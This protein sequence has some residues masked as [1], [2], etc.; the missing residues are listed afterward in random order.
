MY[1][2]PVDL[3]SQ[4][5]VLCS[6]IFSLCL[7]NEHTVSLLVCA[8]SGQTQPPCSQLTDIPHTCEPT[9]DC[10]G[11]VCTTLSGTQTATLT[12]KKCSDPLEVDLVLM[13]SG[14]SNSIRY[15]VGGPE[16]MTNNS[17]VGQHRPLEARFSRNTTHLMFTVSCMCAVIPLGCYTVSILHQ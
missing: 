5:I 11:L 6:I 12:I 7:F 9:P 3:V 15:Y 13:L 4:C 1:G 16:E 8:V 2:Q 10:I 14:S 17:I